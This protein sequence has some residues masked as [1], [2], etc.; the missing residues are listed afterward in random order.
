MY[1]SIDLFNC[2]VVRISGLW[3]LLAFSFGIM[4]AMAAFDQYPGC[5]DLQRSHFQI[6][7]IFGN[8]GQLIKMDFD[9]VAPGEVDIYFVERLLVS[10]RKNYSLMEQ[11][12]Q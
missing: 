1:K 4:P 12:V 9:L 11:V 2:R 5:T 10:F 8:V 6:E 3:L 7:T